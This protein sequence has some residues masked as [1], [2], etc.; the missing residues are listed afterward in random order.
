MDL[1]RLCFIDASCVQ[2]LWSASR[3]LQRNGGL[4]KLVAPQPLVARVLAL[5]E[6][7]RVIGVH[8]SV[9]GAVVATTG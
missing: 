6:A 3:Q 8:E 5:C 4:L 7:D 1:S 2:E 9:A